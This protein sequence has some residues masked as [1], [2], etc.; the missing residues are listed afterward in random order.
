M[1]HG[2][3]TSASSRDSTL[4]AAMNDEA[5][6]K[7][8]PWVELD[9]AHN[10]RDLGGLPAGTQRTRSGVLL[11]GDAVD[12]LTDAD[13]RRLVDDVGLVRVIDL[14]TAE[15]RTERDEHRLAGAG[16]AVVDLEAFS[17]IDL[18]RRRAT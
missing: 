2:R 3:E 6:T 1:R 14:R 10:V 4:P 9:G 16:I 15:E 12:A 7:T 11:R 18:E 13:V 5:A 8:S 17:S